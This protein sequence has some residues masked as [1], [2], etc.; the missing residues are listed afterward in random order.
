[1]YIKPTNDS[2]T[3]T[4]TNIL[5][6][7]PLIS[8]EIQR[9]ERTEPMEVG[10]QPSTRNPNKKFG[11]IYCSPMGVLSYHC[12]LCTAQMEH[13]D[14]FSLHYMSHYRDVFQT[15]Q[16]ANDHDYGAPVDPLCTIKLEETLIKSEPIYDHDA[17]DES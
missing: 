9:Y 5:P 8:S 12:V 10:R 13:S 6:N 3:T 11:E 1:M 16:Q 14:E 4:A 7:S 2:T 15:N 17:Y